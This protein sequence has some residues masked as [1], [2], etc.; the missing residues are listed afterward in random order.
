MSCNRTLRRARSTCIKR[1]G[2]KPGQHKAKVLSLLRQLQT[3]SRQV[4]GWAALHPLYKVIIQYIV[5]RVRISQHQG[6]RRRARRPSP[7]SSSSS[8]FGASSTPSN[9]FAL[10]DALLAAD[11]PMAPMDIT[12]MQPSTASFLL[13]PASGPVLSS[14]NLGLPTDTAANDI[15]TASSCNCYV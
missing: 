11:N 5:L 14:F 2:G 3:V 13:T 7:G 9:I 6:G 15:M 8:S 4:L 12:L 1:Q 10:S